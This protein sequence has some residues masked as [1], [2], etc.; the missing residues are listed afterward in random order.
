[1]TQR[2]R[3]SGPVRPR[4]TRRRAARSDLAPSKQSRKADWL[5]PQPWEHHELDEAAGETAAAGRARGMTQAQP[6]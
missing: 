5:P 2:G 6:S 1:M 3:T 4:S